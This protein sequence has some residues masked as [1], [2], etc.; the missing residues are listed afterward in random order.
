MRLPSLRALQVFASVARL[1]SLSRA[2]GSLGVSAS[3]VSHLLKGLEGQIGCR[4]LHRGRGKIVLTEEGQ[5]LF[6][7]L[8]PAFAAIEQAVSGW[9]GH[10][11]E[12]RISTLSTFSVQWLIPRLGRF[13]EVEPRID[14]FI[15]T[16]PR[17]VDIDTENIDAAIRWGLGDWAGVETQQIFQERLIAVAS[18]SLAGRLNKPS[19]ESIL[20]LPLIRSRMRMSDWPVWLDPT[21]RQQEPELRSTIVESQ[22]LAIQAAL[23]GVGAVVLDENMIWEELTSGR[24]VR[25]SDRVVDRAEGYW[26]VWSGNRP[27]RR[28]FQAFR[29][30][31]QSEVGLPPENRSA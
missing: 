23:A 6:L 29:K 22:N 24:L 25:L 12:L 18:P 4:L 2:A 28:T 7:Q 26:L 16:T 10:R 15:A 9:Q 30:W 11:F 13:Q 14:L 3:A 17:L 1:G 27:R 19:V 31:L 20:E 8:E 21:G 5:S